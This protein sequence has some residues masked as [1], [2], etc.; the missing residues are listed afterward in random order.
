MVAKL[1]YHWMGGQLTFLVSG[2]VSAVSDLSL[3]KFQYCV[4]E[5]SSHESPLLCAKIFFEKFDEMAG[6]EISLRARAL[7]AV[8]QLCNVT[9]CTSGGGL[10]EC[11]KF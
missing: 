7:L 6:E 4:H 8:A 3:S 9:E 2:C 11:C 5:I 10:V 1:L